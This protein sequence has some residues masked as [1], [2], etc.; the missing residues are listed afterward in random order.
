MANPVLVWENRYE[1]T[2]L[3]QVMFQKLENMEC[4]LVKVICE[5]GEGLRVFFRENI[6]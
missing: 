6:F 5:I 2:K 4:F 1:N 3:G